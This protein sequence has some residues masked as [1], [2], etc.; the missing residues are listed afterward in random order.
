MPIVDPSFYPEFRSPRLS[1]LR[2]GSCRI[3]LRDGDDLFT[4]LLPLATTDEEL[5]ELALNQL[6]KL[7]LRNLCDVTYHMRPFRDDLPT[8][9]LPEDRV[10]ELRYM[11][12]LNGRVPYINQGAIKRI[13]EGYWASVV[14]LI[15]RREVESFPGC[16]NFRGISLD[17]IRA[18]LPEEYHNARLETPSGEEDEDLMPR[19]FTRLPRNIMLSLTIYQPIP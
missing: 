1:V 14:G 15:K 7:A 19:M 5:V 12:F 11:A 16:G 3:L 10:Y 4:T 8:I 13:S 2:E 17:S 9:T 6:M 18:A